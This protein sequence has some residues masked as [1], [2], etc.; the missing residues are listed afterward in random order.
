MIPVPIRK[1]QF[2]W[3]HPALFFFFHSN[4]TTDFIFLFAFLLFQTSYTIFFFF[5][6]KFL[7]TSCLSCRKKLIIVFTS[8]ELKLGT[9]VIHE[10]SLLPWASCRRGGEAL[11]PPRL[12]NFL[13]MLLMNASVATKW[14]KCE[15]YSWIY[16]FTLLDLSVWSSF[17][18]RYQQMLY[19]FSKSTTAAKS[20]CVIVGKAIL[21]VEVVGLKWSGRWCETI[22]LV[23]LALTKESTWEPLTVHNISI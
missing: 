14:G 8:S 3:R 9:L 17:N 12:S 11:P 13:P 5:K 22:N 23:S 16:C 10:D 4:N 7:F 15:K 20:E 19:T 6:G 21:T 2:H 18:I 1:H